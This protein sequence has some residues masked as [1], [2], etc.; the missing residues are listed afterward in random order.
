MK[1]S[2]SRVYLRV[3]VKSKTGVS[4]KNPRRSVTTVDNI[5]RQTQRQTNHSP[6]VDKPHLRISSR[7]TVR[8]TTDNQVAQSTTGG[9]RS[10][11]Q[12]GGK[13][14][15]GG[16]DRG[17]DSDTRRRDVRF[18][19]EKVVQSADGR[20]VIVDDS[21]ADV[22][23]HP[24]HSRRLQSHSG[25]LPA[26]LRGGHGAGRTPP[27]LD[28]RDTD[29]SRV[30]RKSAQRSQSRPLSAVFDDDAVPS[31]SSVTVRTGSVPASI[32]V[33]HRG[34]SAKS[35]KVGVLPVIQPATRRATDANYSSSVRVH[36]R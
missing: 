5:E 32:N 25:T 9:G 23:R 1:L 15:P 33:L 18:A 28:Q 24:S 4:T 14:R 12:D 10:R 16:A 29:A 26:R 34:N 20:A 22:D 21:M 11:V 7:S 2:T 6:I 35:R 19:K 17:S 13:R 30:V 36:R 27:E 31:G 8:P 3:C